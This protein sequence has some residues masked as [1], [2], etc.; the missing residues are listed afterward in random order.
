MQS[1]FSKEFFEG[2][3]RRLKTLFIG[4]APIVITA[5]GRLQR[6][7]DTTFPFRQDSNFWYLTGI[8]EPDFI[9]VMDK[10]KEYLIAPKR[11]EAQGVM[12]GLLDL[13]PLNKISGLDILDNEIGWKQLGAR[14]SRVKHIATLA[15]LPAYI[16]QYG[17]YA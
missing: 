3:R 4:K 11:S 16:N 5:N 12:E 2:N 13:K 9:L 15:A 14:L 7:G 6:S 8:N 17:F 1:Y 10:D